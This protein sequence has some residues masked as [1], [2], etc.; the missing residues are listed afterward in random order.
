M[1]QRQIISLIRQIVQQKGFVLTYHAEIRRRERR[2]SRRDVEDILL[3][4]RRIIRE[5]VTG[6]GNVI[7]KI[8]GGRR[9]RKLAVTIQDGQVVILTVM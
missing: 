1:D 6:S 3:N 4:V 7:Y 8:Q 2:L 9:N 5:D